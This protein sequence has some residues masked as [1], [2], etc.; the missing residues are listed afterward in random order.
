[1]PRRFRSAIAS[2]I[3]RLHEAGV[4]DEVLDHLQRALIDDIRWR[5]R[6][7]GAY[8]YGYGPLN[9]GFPYCPWSYSGFHRPY[10]GGPWGC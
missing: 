2:D 10:L 4:A 9:R 1:M 3:V 7:S 5:D 8:W 6:Y